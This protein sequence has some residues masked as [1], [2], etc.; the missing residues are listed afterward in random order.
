MAEARLAQ[1]CARIEA[2]GRE[3]QRDLPKTIAMIESDPELAR[4]PAGDLAE[5]KA[6]L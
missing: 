3:F 6:A 5:M 2:T 4:E 1:I